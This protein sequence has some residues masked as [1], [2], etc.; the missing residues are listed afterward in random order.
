MQAIGNFFGGD[1]N[2]NM[3]KN[4]TAIEK[5]T[6]TQL[7]NAK[8]DNNI[9]A[10]EKFISFGQS[11]VGFKGGDLSGISDF[12][13]AMVSSAHGI[14]YALHGGDDKYGVPGMFNDIKIKSGEGL[15]SVGIME[16]TDAS[17]GVAVLRHS[18][19]NNAPLQELRAVSAEMNASTGGMTIIAPTDS[20]ITT[21]SSATHI[22]ELEAI[23]RQAATDAFMNSL[24][25]Q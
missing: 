20:S 9:S 7:D 13:E 23:A 25:E 11:M 21:S 1:A 4:I 22:L 24:A 17:L 2:A 12:A 5:F 16:M 8:V 10:I 14:K 6:E 19:T 3:Q 18:L 15:S